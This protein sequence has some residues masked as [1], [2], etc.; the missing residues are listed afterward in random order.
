MK[1]KILL[2]NSIILAMAPMICVY[3]FVQGLTYDYLFFVILLILS[4]ILG[5]LKP[6]SV[7]ASHLFIAVLFCGFLSYVTNTGSIWYSDSLYWHN[8]VPISISFFV[9]MFLIP[10]IEVGI[11][12]KT[13]IVCG[14]ITSVICIIQILSVVTFGFFVPEMFF[15]PGLEV[16]RALHT[17]SMTRPCSLFTEPAHFCIFISPIAYLM[18]IDGKKILGFFFIVSMISSTSTTGLLLAG[19]IV[20][21]YL[22]RVRKLSKMFLFG[23]LAIIAGIIVYAAFPTVIQGSID[24]LTNT[25]ADSDVRLLGPLAYMH[26]LNTTDII[27]G[28]GINQLETFVLKGGGNLATEGS[29]NYANATLYI[30]FSYGI[31][32]FITL[33]SYILKLWKR[34]KDKGFL[35][36][37]LAIL[38]SDQ[39]LFSSRFIYLMTFAYLADQFV[40]NEEKHVQ[41]NNSYTGGLDSGLSTNDGADS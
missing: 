1:N 29:G 41:Q 11:Y 10:L 21:A 39:I 24:K 40:K 18:L 37:F 12:K 14:I 13:L 6:K 30:F 27:Y 4:F 5:L 17:I 23:V 36:I 28:I 33:F 35:L 31:I 16:T 26:L 20:F 9:I 15:P 3:R 2:I 7:N 22:C 8:L 25:D 34:S 19:L 38:C 32:G